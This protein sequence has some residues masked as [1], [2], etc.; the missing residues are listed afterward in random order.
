[1]DEKVIV[2]VECSSETGRLSI[3]ALEKRMVAKRVM[4]M[5]DGPFGGLGP[6]WLETNVP[7][8]RAGG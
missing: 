5:C 2:L 7:L 4:A 8:P 1:M 6:D 3:G